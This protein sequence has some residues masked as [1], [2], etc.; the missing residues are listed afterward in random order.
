M[1]TTHTDLSQILASLRGFR[2][3]IA[4]GV[5]QMQ[6]SK[7]EAELEADWLY[8]RLLWHGMTPV[9]IATA[10]SVVEVMP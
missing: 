9:E 10:V 8:S 2:D 3:L 4:S 1:D 7:D 6:Q 5:L